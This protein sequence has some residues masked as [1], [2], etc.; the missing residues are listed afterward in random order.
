MD[1]GHEIFGQ[2]TGAVNGLEAVTKGGTHESDLF[3][4]HGWNSSCGLGR[5]CGKGSKNGGM[6]KKEGC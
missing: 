2:D 4:G 5:E 3:F 6:K 1:G